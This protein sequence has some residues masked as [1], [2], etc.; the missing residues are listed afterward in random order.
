MAFESLERLQLSRYALTS[1][2]YAHDWDG[3]KRHA[4]LQEVHIAAV[5]SCLVD[6]LPKLCSWP[7]VASLEFE[8]LN[9]SS[10]VVVFL[11]L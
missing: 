5:A 9:G 6:Y 10:L 4:S 7:K 11:K 3:L 1:T 2:S 8:L